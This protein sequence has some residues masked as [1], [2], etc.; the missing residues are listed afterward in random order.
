MLQV[1]FWCVTC[2]VFVLQVKFLCCKSDVCNAGQYFLLQVKFMYWKCT[3]FVLQGS[4][5]CCESNFSCM[6]NV[7]QDIICYQSHFGVT[8]K[9]FLC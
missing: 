4:F 6:Q 3:I 9:F 1:R 2:Q 8:C 7:L 5:S